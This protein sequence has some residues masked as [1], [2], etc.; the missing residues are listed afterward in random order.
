MTLHR[1]RPYRPSR[2]RPRPRTGGAGRDPTRRPMLFAGIA[3][4]VLAWAGSAAAGPAVIAASRVEAFSAP[5]QQS[6]VVS[7]L[8]QGAPVCVL[9]RTNYPGVLL[10]RQGWLAIRLPGGVGYVPVETVDLAA[11]AP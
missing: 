2:R 10:H 6:S 5:S 7:E 4:G 9:D 8:G 1:N 3:A 11:P